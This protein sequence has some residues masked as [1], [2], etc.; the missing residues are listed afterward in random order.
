[1][2]YEPCSSCTT[3]GTIWEKKKANYDLT[4]KNLEYIKECIDA[5][6]DEA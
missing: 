6:S 2:V 4:G 1:L 5:E 3:D